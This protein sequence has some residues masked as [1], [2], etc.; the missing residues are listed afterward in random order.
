M[1]AQ[2]DVSSLVL[3]IGV[4]TSFVVGILTIHYFLKLIKRISLLFFF[5]YRLLLGG[6]LFY[7]I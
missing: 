7:L 2:E 4:V 1:K 3:V 6:L 5:I